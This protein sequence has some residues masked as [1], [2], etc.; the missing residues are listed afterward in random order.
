MKKRLFVAIPLP[1]DLAEEIADWSRSLKSRELRLTPKENLHFTVYF[2][3]YVDEEKIAVLA[4]ALE[5]A[6][7]GI[8]PFPL[9]FEKIIFAPPGKS[10]RMIWAVFQGEGYKYLRAEVSRSLRQFARRDSARLEPIVHATLARFKDR[11]LAQSLALKQPRFT[12][13]RFL[14][15]RVDLMESV[16]SRA[17]PSYTILRSFPLRL[18]EE[19]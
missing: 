11:R 18:K 14:V 17:G 13:S 2:I 6:L 4:E 12:A 15:S 16:L 19:K 3:G 9:K 5:Q 10:P 7:V 1:Q 8:K